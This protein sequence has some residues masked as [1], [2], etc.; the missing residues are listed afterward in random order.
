LSKFNARLF[1]LKRS[2]DWGNAS[3][4]QF[5]KWSHLGWYTSYHA[6]ITFFH[7]ISDWLF[8]NHPAI[9]PYI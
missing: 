5:W 2:F 3:L 4:K 8:I 9:L 7:V 6:T 1:A